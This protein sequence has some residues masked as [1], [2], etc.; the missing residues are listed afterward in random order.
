MSHEFTPLPQICVLHSGR[1]QGCRTVL[2][3][4]QESAFWNKICLSEGVGF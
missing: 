3:A 4:E 1:E 2:D